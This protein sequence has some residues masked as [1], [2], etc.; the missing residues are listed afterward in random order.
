MLVREVMT[1]PVYTV[2]AST[3]VKQAL[4][5]LDEHAIT[6]MPVVD[7]RGRPIGVVSEVDLLW[8]A[9]RADQRRHEIPDTSEPDLP[10]VVA[11]VM[12]HH[13][14]T[15]TPDSDL[16]EA[17]DLMMSSVVKSLPVLEHGRVIG[18]VSRRDVVHA[19][20]RADDEI[21][22][23]V[24]DLLRAVAPD[25]SVEVTD[26]QVIVEGPGSDSEGRLASAIAGSVPGV[27]RIT[28]A[29]VVA[30]PQRRKSP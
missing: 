10:R 30:R 18:I 13:P 19:L 15:V 27:V 24:D 9:L 16:S 5:V 6:A 4:R 22:A 1:S 17:V 12:N 3:T 26:G 7:E 23:E 14:I 20:A 25:W 11:E 28:I 8:G 2:L 29:G 21:R